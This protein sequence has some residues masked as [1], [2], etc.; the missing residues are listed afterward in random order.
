MR[1]RPE[2]I[3]FTTGV[4]LM[5]TIV[6]AVSSSRSDLLKKIKEAEALR[7]YAGKPNATS[8]VALGSLHKSSSLFGSL[9]GS[10]E[11]RA[12]PD[13]VDT[14]VMLLAGVNRPVT[15]W[16]YS[17]QEG[18]LGAG[19]QWVRVPAVFRRWINSI[20][21]NK[22][23]EVKI[24]RTKGGRLGP[25]VATPEVLLSP[26]DRVSKKHRPPSKR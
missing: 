19:K 25:D 11:V 3:F 4:F 22:K 1:F 26:T 9:K 12:R 10:E 7:V 18:L 23:T 5:A 8:G 6:V 20:N 14:T 15:I 16:S 21:R 24:L 13:K 2:L 17:S